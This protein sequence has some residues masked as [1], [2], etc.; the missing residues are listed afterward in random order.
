MS[1]LV[2]IQ[3]FEWNVPADGEHWKRLT[4]VA[5]RL[6][7]LGIHGIWI[8]PCIKG[9]G[10]TDVGYGAYDLWDLGE[11][12]QKNTVRTK[13]GTRQELIDACK[14]CKDVGIQVYA[15][16]VLNH[17]LGADEKETFKVVE[18]DEHDRTKVISDEHDITAW[19]KFTFPG[20]KGQ[21]S[22]FQWSFV[23]FSGTDWDDAAQKKAIYK[24]SGENKGWALGVDNEG[25]NYDYLMG[26]NID[27]SH[28]DVVAETKKWAMW[29]VNLLGLGGFRMDALKHIDEP[30][31]KS[32]LDHVRAETGNPKFFAVGEYWRNDIKALDH[33]FKGVDWSVSLFDVPLHFNFYEASNKGKDYDM[34]QIFDGTLI[35]NHPMQAVTF[36]DNHDSQPDE[37][38]S[39]WVQ[40]WFKPLA[41][42]LILLRSE[43]YPCIFYGDLYGISGGNPIPGRPDVLAKL[44][45]ARRDYAYGE[46][47]DYFDHPTTVGWVRRGKQ[48]CTNPNHESRKKGLAVV[49]CTGEGGD[50]RMF[51][52][53]Q[54]AGQKWKDLLGWYQEEVTIGDDGFGDFKANGGSVSVWANA[55]P[56]DETRPEENPE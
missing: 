9:S 54:C 37:A 7:K 28:P 10:P 18:V 49:M 50:K 6:A 35:K 42:A 56:I 2:M 20:R 33:Y 24:I 46:E 26:C 43:G 13:Y 8:P 16:V 19:T 30:F 51:V 32:L 27:Y 4:K 14:K 12:D 1:N 55:D 3:F 53:E 31:V 15:D 17:K 23:H 41:Y 47:N 11:F 29:L 34:R 21:Y 44:M 52:G 38:L 39:S 45:I 25:N 5:A 40:D 48:D 36:V 22:E